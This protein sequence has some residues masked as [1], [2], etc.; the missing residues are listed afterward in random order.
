MAYLT[1]GLSVSWESC[2]ERERYAD[3]KVHSNSE[4]NSRM[5]RTYCR[6]EEQAQTLLHQAV[7]RLGFSARAYDRVL[8]LA[9]TIADLEGS[10]TITAAHVSE[11]IAY[12]SL[13]RHF[14]V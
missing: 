6:P 13:D 14:K 10:E 1:T 7:D 3:A 12:R 11:G 9:R 8:K 2:R 4:L 5:I